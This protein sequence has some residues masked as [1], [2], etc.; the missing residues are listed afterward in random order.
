MGGPGPHWGLQLCVWKVSLP[1]ALGRTRCTFPPKPAKNSVVTSQ[2]LQ[3]GQHSRA[4]AGSDVFDG[5]PGRGCWRCDGSRAQC[6]GQAACAA[7]TVQVSCLQSPRGSDKRLLRGAEE[8]ASTAFGNELKAEDSPLQ[9]LPQLPMLCLLELE[10]GN[11]TR[12]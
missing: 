9:A 2:F 3:E 11:S 4:R 6:S 8:L 5:V 1:V 12:A 7:P 10:R